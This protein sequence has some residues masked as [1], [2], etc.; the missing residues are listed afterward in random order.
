MNALE[1]KIAELAAWR[2]STVKIT[3]R[4]ENGCMMKIISSGETR[5]V[6]HPEASGLGVYGYPGEMAR[7]PEMEA[8]WAKVQEAV[9]SLHDAREA[10]IR[11][12]ALEL[13][14]VVHGEQL[15]GIRALV[16]QIQEGAGS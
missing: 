15:N 8:A 2:T 14:N 12:K 11:R 13:A 9:Q 5:S 3:T 16:D 4:T 6:L 7:E 10:I 1:T